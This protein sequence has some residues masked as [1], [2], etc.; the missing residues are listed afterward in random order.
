MKDITY[1]INCIGLSPKIY[2]GSSHFEKSL[3]TLQITDDHK[4]TDS[5]NKLGYNNAMQQKN[6]SGRINVMIIFLDS[7]D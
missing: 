3:G 6:R 4:C 2:M 1:I 7:Y 5:D